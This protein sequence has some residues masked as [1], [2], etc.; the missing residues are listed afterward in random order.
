MSQGLNQAEGIPRYMRSLTSRGT[1]R[2]MLLDIYTVI[3]RK[4]KQYKYSAVGS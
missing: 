3:N 2:K 1:V 4:S